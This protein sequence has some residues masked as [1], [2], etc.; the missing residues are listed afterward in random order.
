MHKVKRGAWLVLAAL[1]M[2]ASAASAQTTGRI[3]GSVKDAQG[4]ALPGATV[5][6]TGPTLQGAQT[7]VTDQDGAF[8]FLSLPPGVTR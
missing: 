7:Q 6:V 4:A 5:T 2:S 1:L 3:M 8:R